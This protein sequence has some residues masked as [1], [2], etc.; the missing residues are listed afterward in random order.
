ML[1]GSQLDIALLHFYMRKAELGRRLMHLLKH[2]KIKPTQNDPIIKTHFVLFHCPYGHWPATLFEMKASTRL[3]T[4]REMPTC[5]K[6][7]IL[8]K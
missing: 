7:T 5:E 3:R 8:R 2:L 4:W 1:E 6:P